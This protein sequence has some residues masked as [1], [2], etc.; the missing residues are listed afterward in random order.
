MVEEI[1]NWEGIGKV[2]TDN[3]FKSFNEAINDIDKIFKASDGEVK[4]ALANYKKQIDAF[5]H[6]IGRVASYTNQE[7]AIPEKILQTLEKMYN[8]LKNKEKGKFHFAK[9]AL[10]EAIGGWIVSMTGLSTF[11][12]GGFVDLLGK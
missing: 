3:F 1:S 8:A 9:G 5:L 12:S 4:S 6:Q 2:Q 10:W 11:I 7:N